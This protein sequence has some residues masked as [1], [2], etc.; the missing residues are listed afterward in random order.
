MRSY[1]SK[2]KVEE[3]TRTI[4]NEGY[5]IAELSKRCGVSRL[6]TSKWLEVL[7]LE[8][9]VRII[10]KPYAK[11]ILK[12]ENVPESTLQEQNTTNSSR[13]GSPER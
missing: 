2:E 4:P 8:G 9:K 7:V 5:S 1:N 10:E 6:T 3:G 11:I 12:N 13:G